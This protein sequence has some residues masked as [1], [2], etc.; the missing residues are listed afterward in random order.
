MK[1]NNQQSTRFYVW[2]TD[3]FCGSKRPNFHTLVISS[4]VWWTQIFMTERFHGFISRVIARNPNSLTFIFERNFTN[5]NLF[6]SV[7]A[8]GL[9]Q[10]TW[11]IFLYS[12]VQACSESFFHKN[13]NKNKHLHS[14]FQFTYCHR[15]DFLWTHQLYHGNNIIMVLKIVFSDQLKLRSRCKTALISMPCQHPFLLPSI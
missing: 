7:T 2:W 15:S 10:T 12:F 4:H 6:L 3:S 11:Q 8:Q 9:S 5:N 1:S 13:L 14:P